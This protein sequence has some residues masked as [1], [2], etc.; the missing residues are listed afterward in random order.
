[1]KT[2][3][4]FEKYM[5]EATGKVDMESIIKNDPVTPEVGMSGQQYTEIADQMKK[6]QLKNAMGEIRMKK[7]LGAKG[8]EGYSK[9]VPGLVKKARELLD[10][11]VKKDPTKLN[12]KGSGK[13]G[14]LASLLGAGTAAFAPES[15]AAEVV[16]KIGKAA[17]S[18]DPSTYLQKQLDDPSTSVE[19][20]KA[21]AEKVK[22]KDK[23]PE[24]S[25]ESI[26]RVQGL[27]QGNED[28]SSLLGER[29]VP[30]ME[31]G[32]RLYRYKQEDELK[33]KLGY[34]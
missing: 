15:K 11:I 5:D 1:M 18:V 22:N 17:E 14:V 16:Q 26:G 27:L 8:L 31:D 13:F 3:K 20:I 34:K 33:K 7:A 19:A 24:V 23:I 21:Y 29:N 32:E 2:K 12:V 30:D 4:S 6:E 9:Q 28:T 10:S 25:E